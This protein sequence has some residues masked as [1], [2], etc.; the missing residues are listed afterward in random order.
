MNQSL[1]SYAKAHSSVYE[2][3]SVQGN[4]HL[5]RGFGANYENWLSSTLLVNHYLADTKGCSA[6]K[7]HGTARNRGRIVQFINRT[8]SMDGSFNSRRRDLK[9]ASVAAARSRN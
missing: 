6:R 3:M 5:W 8:F 1:N 2:A 7:G 4:D 9:G